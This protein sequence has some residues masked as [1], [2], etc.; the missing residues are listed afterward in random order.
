MADISVNS[1]T[2]VGVPVNVARQ[3]VTFAGARAPI[4]V[5]EFTNPIATSGTSLRAATASV[6]TERT[7]TSFLAGGV[8]ALADTPRQIAFVTAGTTPADA[9]ATA[10]ITGTDANGDAQ[11][12]TVNIAQTATSAT[13][14]KFFS[15][16]TSIVEAAG[17]G[18]GA[19]ISI[20]IGAALGLRRKAKVRGGVVSVI[21]ETA[22]GARVTTGTFTVPASAPP[23]G[24]YTPSS[25]ANG[26]ND[27]AIAYELDLT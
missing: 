25:A 23:N 10:T 27:Y 20:G 4:Y 21:N 7:T 17:D 15:S 13:S 18:T 3:L 11:T 16:I 12:E 6:T 5:D 19:T 8:A 22:A 24:S 2:R 1:L 9:P 14:T 26:T